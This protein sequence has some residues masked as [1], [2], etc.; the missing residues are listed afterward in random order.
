[1]RPP[2]DPVGAVADELYG[3]PPTDFTAARDAMVKQARAAGDRVTAA[4]IAALRKPTVA[5]WLVNL[6]V[7]DQP[8]EISGFVELGVALREATTSLSGP[9]LRELSSQRHRLVQAL[10]SQARA[11]GVAAGQKVG[12]DTLR[13]VEETLHAVLADPA[14]AEAVLSGRL[15]QPLSRTG[16]VPPTSPV[17]A[18]PGADRPPTAA[19]PAEPAAPARGTSPHRTRDG[20]RRA[21][22]EQRRA[23]EEQRRAERADLEQQLAQ[24]WAEAAA[25]GEARDRAAD[26]S[27]AAARRLAAA[28]QELA[29]LRDELDRATAAHADEQQAAGLAE[30]RHREATALADETRSRVRDL[31][32]RLDRL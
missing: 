18:S 25:A 30:D 17:P 6:L 5:A 10:V 13:A 24:A 16:F 27:S 26:E 2:P 4:A 21:K 29:R 3:V 31:Q 8:E 20:Q 19:D 14:A 22:E 1:M 9:A 7:R 11:L 32:R 28:A 15:A 12:E 23:M